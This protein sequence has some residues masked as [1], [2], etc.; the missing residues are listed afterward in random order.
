MLLS[1]SVCLTSR[2]SLARTGG[3]CEFEEEHGHRKSGRD[4]YQRVAHQPSSLSLLLDA[5]HTINERSYESF[6][7]SSGSPFTTADACDAARPTRAAH[8]PRPLPSGLVLPP[9]LRPAFLSAPLPFARTKRRGSQAR[10]MS[11]E[12]SELKQS[13]RQKGKVS[14]QSS[15]EFRSERGKERETKEFVVIS[16]QC[17]YD[18]NVRAPWTK[19]RGPLQARRIKTI[20]R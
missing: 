7:R 8:A 18:I 5:S 20:C 9:P 3:L 13:G 14:D 2:T 16:P 4:V 17:N 6:P 15:S 1:L 11:A 19:R 12:V 10:L